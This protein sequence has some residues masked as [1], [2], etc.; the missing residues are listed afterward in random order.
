MALLAVGLTV[1]KEFTAGRVARVI[2]GEHLPAPHGGIDIERIKLEPVALAADALRRDH[3]GAAAQKAIEYE[4]TARGAVH[5]RV[6]HQRHR[7]HR[8]MEREQVALL[9]APAEGVDPRIAPDVAAVT[10]E[11]PQLDVVA[12]R[13]AAALEDQHQ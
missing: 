10:P 12:M 4:R 8:R 9:A 2:A 3:R 11:L 1:G 13:A 6:G 5:H 7:L